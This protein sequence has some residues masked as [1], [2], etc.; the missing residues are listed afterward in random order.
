MFELEHIEWGAHRLC[1]VWHRESDSGLL[2]A[3]GRGGC[4][5]KLQLHGWDFLCGYQDAAELDSLDWARSAWLFPFPNRLRDGRYSWQGQT[6]SFP[7]N[8][9]PTGN[10]IHGFLLGEPMRLKSVQLEYDFV[11]VQLRCGYDGHHSGYPFPFELSLVYSLHLNGRFE[12]RM[13]VENRGATEAPF[14]WGWHPYFRVGDTSV[15]TW[16]LRIPAADV[17]EV[18]KRMLPT[19]QMNT[20]D[21]GSDLQPIGGR[22]F[23]HCLQLHDSGAELELLGNRGR[24]RWRQNNAPYLQLFTPP[25]RDSLAIEP[26]SCGVDA[27][28]TGEGLLRLAPSEGSELGVFLQMEVFAG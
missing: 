15:D 22:E 24:I 12:T 19:G 18:D 26:M 3:P 20:L 13:Q 17:A 9:A 4:L 5:L 25:M 1:K 27:F 28:N 23:D 11:E 21:F 8:D 14:G 7:I 2:I 6:Y 16:K 10:A